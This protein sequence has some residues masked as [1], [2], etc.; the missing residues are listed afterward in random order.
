[1]QNMMTNMFRNFDKVRFLKNRRTQL[2]VSHTNTMQA[3]RMHTAYICDGLS[4]DEQ[5]TSWQVIFWTLILSITTMYNVGIFLCWKEI[6]SFV[7]LDTVLV[8]KRHWY[9][10][11][12]GLPFELLIMTRVIYYVRAAKC[13]AV[14]HIWQ[15]G[16]EDELW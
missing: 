16:E 15:S 13:Q 11:R 10:W 2:R 9:G 6:F 8:Y 5:T 4:H 1:M 7:W 3:I 12:Y 14:S